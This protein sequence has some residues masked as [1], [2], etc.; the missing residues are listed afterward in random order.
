MADK[1]V[2]GTQD[3][4]IDSILNEQRKFE[5][6]PE[7]SKHAHI[8]TLEEYEHVYKESVADPEKFWSRIASELHW[9]RSGT[10]FSNGI[11]RG[12]NGLSAAKSICLTTA[13]TVMS[14]PG[15]R[16]KPR[17]FGRASPATF[18]SLPI[19]NC[20]AKCRSSPTS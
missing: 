20:I 1:F 19:S 7:F 9:L 14:K 6:P 4:N 10:R 15:A 2:V 13:W 12:R 18:A 17:S 5:C 8:K 11:A 16:I 3:P